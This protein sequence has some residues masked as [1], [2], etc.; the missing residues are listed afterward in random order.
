MNKYL[1]ATSGL[2]I[3]VVLVRHR[4]LCRPTPGPGPQ[5]HCQSLHL[6]PVSGSLL[7][8]LDLLR[9]GGQSR[10][11]RVDL[12]A[13]LPG[14]HSDGV[15]LVVPGSQIDPHLQNQ[16]HHHHGRFSDP[17]L[18]PGHSAGGMVTIWLI[19]TD[20]PYIGLQLKAVS[21]T[22]NLLVGAPL[23]QPE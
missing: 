10:Q 17:A 12:P 9:F 18:W 22:F 1:V 16:P 4:L 23:S 13:H 20:M 5:P 19:L 8:L 7:H 3:S 6:Y 14:T 15:S 2:R 21:T 11:R